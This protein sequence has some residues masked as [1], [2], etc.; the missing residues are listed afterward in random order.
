MV[1]FGVVALVSLGLARKL[2]VFTRGGLDRGRLEAV[3]KRP[4]PVWLALAA[5]AFLGQAI[6]LAVAQGTGL[7]GEGFDA[8]ARLR[9]VAMGVGVG[10]AVTLAVVAERLAPRSGLAFRRRDLGVGLLTFGL[11]APVVAFVALVAAQIGAWITGP[12]EG[13]A[14]ETLR[15]LVEQRAN[16]SAWALIAVVVI[17]APIVEEIVYRG[18][19][20]SSLLAASKSAWV[21]IGVTSVVF[22]LMHWEALPPD[23][24][25]AL[26]PLF[27]LSVMLG[28]VVERTG[29]VWPAVVVHALFN[30]SNVGVAFAIA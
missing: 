15:A 28:V 6:G 2:G 19:L 4:S 22:T 18:F 9:L 16:P 11:I 26:A 21:A 5:T 12:A 1:A 23:G 13:A 29:R 25:H 27:A 17:G 24:K 3:L 8:E 14:H 10:I 7:G 20:Q 30:A